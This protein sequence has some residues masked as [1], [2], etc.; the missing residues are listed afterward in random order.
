MWR[1]EREREQA[2][3]P[4]PK[5]EVDVVL[6]GAGLV[7]VHLPY[8]RGSLHFLLPPRA[9][10]VYKHDPFRTV[11]YRWG[12][13]GRATE[14]YDMCL[15]YFGLGPFFEA[16][17]LPSERPPAPV[18]ALGRVA[19][20]ISDAIDR[21]LDVLEPRWPSLTQTRST[22]LGRVD[23]W[24]SVVSVGRLARVARELDP[25]PCGHPGCRWSW[26][27][28]CLCPDPGIEAGEV[29]AHGEL[30]LRLSLGEAHGSVWVSQETWSAW[31]GA[32]GWR[33]PDETITHEEEPR[34]EGAEREGNDDD[35]EHAW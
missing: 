19:G 4:P 31:G 9:C 35:D 1:S 13:W 28:A 33:Y 6:G 25:A 10:S 17:W 26:S 27:Q 18:R 2:G 8:G 24:L 32:A 11:D 5:E 14:P 20:W 16:C 22:L 34:P 29:D 23:A 21:G 3:L 15:E 12:I 7:S 30:E